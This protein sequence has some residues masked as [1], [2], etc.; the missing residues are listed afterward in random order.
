MERNAVPD[1]RIFELI[2]HKCDLSWGARL[3]PVD[4]PSAFIQRGLQ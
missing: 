3:F 2:I 1:K 4:V